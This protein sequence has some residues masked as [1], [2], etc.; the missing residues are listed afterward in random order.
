[1]CCNNPVGK[2]SD[3]CQNPKK[4]PEALVKCVQEKTKE[5]GLESADQSLWGNNIFDHISGGRTRLD[6]KD[7]S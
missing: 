3:C 2:I 5:T 1:M 4:V 7:P 6:L